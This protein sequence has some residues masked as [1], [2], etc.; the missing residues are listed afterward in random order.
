MA[1]APAAEVFTSGGPFTML[2]VKDGTATVDLFLEQREARELA[3]AIEDTA[4]KAAAGTEYSV[5]V[6]IDA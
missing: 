6:P 4:D 3:A 1:Y 5:A 2:T